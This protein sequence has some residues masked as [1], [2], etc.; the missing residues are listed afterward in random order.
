MKINCRSWASIDLN[1]NGKG[2]MKIEGRENTEKEICVAMPTIYVFPI[3]L[4]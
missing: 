3:T 1:P 4:R 2:K